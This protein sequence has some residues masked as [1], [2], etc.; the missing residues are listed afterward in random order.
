MQDYQSVKIFRKGLMTITGLRRYV[1]YSTPMHLRFENFGAVQ[2]LQGRG[3]KP[4]Q[5][6]EIQ[7]TEQPVLH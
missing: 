2:V 1:G 7:D 6:I 3:S 5:Q 4:V